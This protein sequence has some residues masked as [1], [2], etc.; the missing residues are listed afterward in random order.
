[1]CRVLIL[2][3]VEQSMF[4]AELLPTSASS[5]TKVEQA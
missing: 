4:Q 5:P 3:T 1:M 2:T